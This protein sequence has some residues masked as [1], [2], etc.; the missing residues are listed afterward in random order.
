MKNTRATKQN[1]RDHTLW[2]L[3]EK[4]IQNESKPKT[5]INREGKK[6]EKLNERE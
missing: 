2:E 3:G 1:G 4:K 6:K 5:H